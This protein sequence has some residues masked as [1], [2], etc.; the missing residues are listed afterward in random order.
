MRWTLWLLLA[1]FLLGQGCAGKSY[2]YTDPK[3]QISVTYPGTVDIFNDQKMLQEQIDPQQAAVDRPE[4]LFVLTTMNRGQ[5][6]FSVHHLPE[7]QDL[8]AEAYYEASTAA[9]LAALEADI[10]EPRTEVTV[11]GKSYL[12]VGFIVKAGERSV[13]SRIYQ[14]FDKQRGR[15]LVITTSA[16]SSEWE[17]EKPQME[18]LVK[19]VKVGW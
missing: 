18:A 17:S 19:S 3:Y 14:H 5:V 2:T 9:E 11:N 15:I 6:T 10:I 13:H 8:T 1:L 12:R 4:L 16:L 7:S